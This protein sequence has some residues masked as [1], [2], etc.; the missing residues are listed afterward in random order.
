MASA[1]AAGSE[2][3]RPED[4]VT[5]PEGIAT[6]ILRGDPSR[7]YPYVRAI[8]AESGGTFAAVSEAEIRLA[9]EQVEELEAIRPCF[10]AAAALAAVAK[11]RRLG[12]LPSEATVLVNL[13]GRDRA[14]PAPVPIRKPQRA[15]AVR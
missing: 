12:E 5:R 2:A 11:L 15:G 8:V 13:T 1:W 7:A 14:E 10:A 9:R 3:I 4:V 6:A